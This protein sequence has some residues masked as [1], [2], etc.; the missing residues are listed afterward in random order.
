MS[1]SNSPMMSALSL[2]ASVVTLIVLIIGGACLKVWAPYQHER[3]IVE[4]IQK[5][6]GTVET[7]HV[8]PAWIPDALH[9]DYL[10]VFE[11]VV[12]VNLDN[13]RVVDA[14]L[15]Q[16]QLLSHL[17]T[18]SLAHT[19]ITD[20]GL[21]HLGKLTHLKGLNLGLTQVTDAG[22]LHLCGLTNLRFILLDNT[23]I[24]DA[25]LSHL[26]KLPRLGSLSLQ[27]TRITRAGLA[28]YQTKAALWH[29]PYYSQRVDP[30]PAFPQSS[31]GTP[32]VHMFG[33]PASP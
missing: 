25:G 2:R 33:N 9:E 7:I 10:T 6:G 20:K 3:Q 21:V 4:E 32:E 18:L 8:R 31:S 11:R 30:V 26:R 15:Q 24:T 22:L 13:S 17:E 5:L 27:A 14:Q 1:E 12:R 16:L 28:R 23:E 19:R 29:D